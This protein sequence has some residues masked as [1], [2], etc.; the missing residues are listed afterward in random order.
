M[1]GVVESLLAA[2]EQN[3]SREREI[4]KQQALQFLGT[5]EQMYMQDPDRV[6][7]SQLVSL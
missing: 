2:L 4:A 3:E 1:K 6:L 7:T 5:L